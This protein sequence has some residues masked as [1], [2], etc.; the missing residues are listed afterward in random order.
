MSL[1]MTQPQRLRDAILDSPGLVAYYRFGDVSGTVAKDETGIN[2]GTYTG[3]PT[4]GVTGMVNGDPNTA[5]STTSVSGQYVT[6]PNAVRDVLNGT[7]W[8]FMV[9]TIMRTNT[10]HGLFTGPKGGVSARCFGSRFNGNAP[11]TNST[12]VGWAEENVA[13]ISGAFM[14]VPLNERHILVNT[15]GAT[16]LT[17]YVDGVLNLAG[18]ISYTWT[19]N[20]TGTMT[21]SS[22][23]SGAD[24][25]EDAIIDEFAIWN[26]R[27]SQLEAARF[28][29]LV[30]GN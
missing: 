4:L 2:D 16:T 12:L 29:Q 17:G 25:S 18:P 15:Y 10:T 21:I 7:A 19:A 26:R 20:F 9:N 6:V 11:G 30:R 23:T 27:L 1:L 3:S 22:S 8:S 24:G 14:T 5:M 13:V 28:S